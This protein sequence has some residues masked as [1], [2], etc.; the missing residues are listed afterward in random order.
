MSAGICRQAS[1]ALYVSWNMQAGLHGS[2][3]KLEYAGSPPWFCMLAGICRQA[4]MALYVSWNMQADPQC[5]IRTAE[6]YKTI[7]QYLF[8]LSLFVCSFE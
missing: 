6:I 4:S 8:Y 3:C 7:L 2:V 5:S 1:T